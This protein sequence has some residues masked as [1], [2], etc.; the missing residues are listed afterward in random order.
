VRNGGL[1]ATEINTSISCAGL[2][3][4]RRKGQPSLSHSGSDADDTTFVLLHKPIG[5]AFVARLKPRPLP[6]KIKIK[7][8]SKADGRMRPSLL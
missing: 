7:V 1:S 8:K 3:F 4:H 5:Y 6:V 2:A